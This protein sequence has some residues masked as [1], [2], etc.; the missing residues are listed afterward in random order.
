MSNE[1]LPPLTN[2]HCRAEMPGHPGTFCGRHAGHA[3]EPGPIWHRQRNAEGGA[4]WRDV[5]PSVAWDLCRWEA[6]L[7]DGGS[8]G[9]AVHVEAAGAAAAVDA[10]A[11]DWPRYAVLRLTLLRGGPSK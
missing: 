4:T 7:D 1:D 3:N 10:V 8:S 9:R 11:R 2:N 5:V 6:I